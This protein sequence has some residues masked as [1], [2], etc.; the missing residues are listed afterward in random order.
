MASRGDC[1]TSSRSVPDGTVNERLTGSTV[2]PLA[3]LALPSTAITRPSP[4]RDAAQIEA[5]DAG[6]QRR[7]GRHGQGKLDGVG[8]VAAAGRGKVWRRIMVWVSVS[9]GWD[10][11]RQGG[12]RPDGAVDAFHRDVLSWLPPGR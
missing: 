12:R 6:G 7:A 11:Q 4:H 2:E 9:S 8:G 10:G 1:T 3:Q 5:A